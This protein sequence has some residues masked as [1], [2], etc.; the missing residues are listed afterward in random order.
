MRVITKILIFILFFSVLPVQT[1]A[2]NQSSAVN[3]LK[4]QPIDDWA[5]M[6]LA[7]S[8]ALSGVNLNLLNQNPGNKATDI[9]KR[10]LARA[11]AGMDD[12][13]LAGKL[14][15]QFNGTEIAAGQGLLNDD[16]FGLLGLAALG[17]KPDIR[18]ALSDFTK[19][20]QNSDGGWGFAH[21]PT[22]SDSN[23]TAM[24]IMALL[25][26]GESR[27]SSVIE[28]GF[29]YISSTKKGAG[30]AFSRGF[31][32]DTAST[33]WVVSALNAAG[34]SV[35]SPAI[36]YLNSQQQPNGSFAW[37]G[38][39][40]GSLLMTAYATIALNNDF[41]PVK[42]TGP[43]GGGGGGGG[44]GEGTGVV[45]GRVI[46]QFGDPVAGAVID[47]CHYGNRL[48][49]SG[50]EWSVNLPRRSNLCARVIGLPDGFGD[51]TSS[52]N[53]PE[54]EFANTYEFQLTGIFCRE[55]GGCS[56]VENE[57]DI[58][59]DLGLNFTVNRK[60]AP[61][62]NPPPPPPANS[63]F[64]VAIISPAKVE[65]AGPLSFADPR[66]I[67]TV[68]FSGINH[69]I[70][71]TSF[72]PYV[73][74]IA[75]FA[76]SGS[77]GWMYAVNGTKPGVGAAEY[78][79]K[80][81]DEVIWFFD[82]FDTGP[83]SFPGAP[84]TQPRRAAVELSAEI[85]TQQPAPSPSV[86]VI[87]SKSKIK[88]GESVTL[89]WSAKNAGSV[90]SA[91][92]DNWAGGRLE[93]AIAIQPIQ[94]TTYSIVVSGSPQASASVTVE[95]ERT[96]SIIFGISANSA[97]F[98]QLQPGQESR[99]QSLTLQNSSASDLEITASLEQNQ[100]LF[101]RGLKIDDRNYDRFK[102]RLSSNQNRNVNLTLAV[103]SN[104]STLG[105]QTDTLIFWAKVK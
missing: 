14:G 22:S 81:G 8:K 101:R 4:S 50:G 68:I 64:D 46:D 56:Q 24:A 17:A 85:I 55:E 36:D 67:N 105:R 97:D 84:G 11:A 3:Y 20:N 19:H 6:A 15:E 61:P 71:D 49:G 7:S 58:A 27:G 10:L 83:P 92:P 13:G 2:Y 31:A 21:A 99:S 74:S 82:N 80:N 9:E 88:I 79:L 37:Q 38:G 42:K 65:F 86:S 73:E 63:S 103:P 100:E 96:S 39:S 53:T 29:D 52:N 89:T 16:I 18:G 30:Y 44:A 26:N 34:R 57:W 78:I 66:A 25:A 93:G 54:T 43:R 60:A 102:E 33:A 35:P 72:G 76:G 45:G 90:V 5:I 75:G 48:T 12:G 91:S 51:A 41:Y 62:A 98:G 23:D 40:S 69:K 70:T 104:Y 94:T 1:D 28:R 77:A 32:E 87:S 95:V 59:D 47:T